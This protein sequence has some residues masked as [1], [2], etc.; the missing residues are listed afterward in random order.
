MEQEA[1]FKYDTSLVIPDSVCKA[2]L[3]I[4]HLLVLFKKE[5][6][7]RKKFTLLKVERAGG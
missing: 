1:D 7:E 2:L 5:K 4:L 6:N 3:V